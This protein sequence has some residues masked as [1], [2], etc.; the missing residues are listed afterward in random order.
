[1]IFLGVEQVLRSA[2]RPLTADEVVC[3]VTDKNRSS[4]YS[5]LR[6]LLKHELVGRLE[7]RGRRKPVVLYEWLG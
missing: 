2:H 1:M 4:A 5:E 7:V 6:T 3:R